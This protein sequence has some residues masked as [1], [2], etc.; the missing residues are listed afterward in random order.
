MSASYAENKP[1]PFWETQTDAYTYDNPSLL[2]DAL[3]SPFDDLTTIANVTSDV[4]EPSTWVMMILGFV[5]VG[6]MA[7]RRKY[8]A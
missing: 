6:L 8:R 1:Y 5:G 3:T 4:P 2:P 7:Y